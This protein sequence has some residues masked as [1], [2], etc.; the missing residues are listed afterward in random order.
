MA[1]R[2]ASQSGSEC[3][4]WASG[5]PTV[6]GGHEQSLAPLPILLLDGMV[7][8]TF[9]GVLVLFHLALKAVKDRS[10]RLLA[11]GV[12]SGDVEELLGGSWALTS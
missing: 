11:Q 10:D 8:G 2:V 6:S 7:G 3:P 5:P 4:L 9:T 12:A 1:P